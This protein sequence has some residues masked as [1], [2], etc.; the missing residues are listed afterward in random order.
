[1]ENQKKKPLW[2]KVVNGVATGLLALVAFVIWLFEPFTGG[3]SVPDWFFYAFFGAI[4][5]AVLVGLFIMLRTPKGR[6]GTP[7]N[8]VKTFYRAVQKGDF[9]AAYYL[10]HPDLQRVHDRS[11][12]RRLDTDLSRL[13]R[14]TPKGWGIDIV[15]QSALVTAY[16]PSVMD[17]HRDRD[18]VVKRDFSSEFLLIMRNNTWEIE[19]YM[20]QDE[21]GRIEGGT[22]PEEGDQGP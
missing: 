6:T 3:I 1:M 10:F 19:A 17:P 18:P 14:R 22:L 20:A 11:E 13:L 12:F 8:V 5:V 21:L 7:Q 16:H 2:R 4:A 9:N 15:D